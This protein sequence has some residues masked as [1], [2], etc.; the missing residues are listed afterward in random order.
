MTRIDPKTGRVA[1][2]RVQSLLWSMVIF[3]IG[4]AL[5]AGVVWIVL[6]T[7][8]DLNEHVGSRKRSPAWFAVV[9]LS[10]AALLVSTFGVLAAVIGTRAAGRAD[11]AAA[12]GHDEVLST[13]AGTI[14]TATDAEPF[15]ELD[16]DSGRSD[17]FSAR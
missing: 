2:T 7:G 12:A 11:A 3:A 4:V 6:R 13:D 16:P 14:A 10:M 8:G 17:G 9:V 5:F 1:P 15:D